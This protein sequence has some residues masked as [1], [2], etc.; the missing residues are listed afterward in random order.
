MFISAACLL[1]TSLLSLSN[2]AMA[3]LPNGRLSHPLLS[4]PP[5][6]YPTV[7]DVNAN[8]IRSSDEVH[9]FDQLID[10]SD[11]SRG[12]FKQRYWTN[13]EYYKTGGPII[14]TTPGAADASGT[15]QLLSTLVNQETT[16]PINH[17]AHFSF[18]VFTHQ[19]NYARSDRS[20]REW[21][22]HP[23]RAT[24]LRSI[25]PNHR[26]FGQEPSSA[27]RRPGYRRFRLLC[28]TCDAFFLRW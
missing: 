16:M 6:I 20:T 18:S 19:H 1:L 23:H 25:Y 22:R 28:E 15:S 13:S 2:H 5:R 24:I 12:T 11:P 7:R 3:G 21:R 8:Q 10:H 27:H 26:F 4:F 14:L 17:D 9:Y